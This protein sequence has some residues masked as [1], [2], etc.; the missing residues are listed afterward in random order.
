MVVVVVAATARACTARESRVFFM[1]V[2]SGVVD[3]FM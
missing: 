2:V 1:V 3:M